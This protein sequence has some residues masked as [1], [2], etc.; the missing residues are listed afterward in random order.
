[1][2][3][4]FLAALLCFMHA[5]PCLAEEEVH[6]VAGIFMGIIQEDGQGP[7]Q[8][9]LRQA[10]AR[11]DIQITETVYPLKRAIRAFSDR[12]ALAIYGMTDAVIKN[13]GDDGIITSY[14]LGVYKLYIFSR[15]EDPPISSYAQL[16]GK[17]L[18]GVIGY[19]EYYREILKHNIQI[20]YLAAEKSQFEKLERGR[21]DAIIG[22][23]PDWISHLSLLSYDPGFPVHIGYDYMTVWDTPAGRSFVNRISPA[24][25]SMHADGT[26][27]KIL[28]ERYMEFEYRPSRKYEWVP[29]H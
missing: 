25:Q 21:I 15:K 14:P 27:K 23:M 22:F 19:E 8:I 12:K 11:A 2:K 7:Y 26:L 16:K 18:G 10:A 3:K 4:I 24:L 28:A 29:G 9:I 6:V 5:G 20:D 17:R 1:M 13:T